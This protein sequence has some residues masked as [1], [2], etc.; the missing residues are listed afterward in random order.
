[1]NRAS[2]NLL[3]GTATLA[4]G[5]GLWLFAGGVDLPLVTPAKA[6]VVMMCVGGAEVLLGLYRAARA[7]A[8]S[9]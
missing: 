1:M 2:R 4:A 8:G 9:R 6:G 5:L 7:P 3:A